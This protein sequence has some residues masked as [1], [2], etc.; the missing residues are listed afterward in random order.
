MTQLDRVRELLAWHA[1][2]AL[3]GQD[4][5]FMH[6]WLEANLA[7]HPEIAA[8]MAWLRNTAEQ[9]QA[10]VQAQ[11]NLAQ[12]SESL[13]LST[14]MQRIALEK[15]GNAENLAGSNAPNQNPPTSNSRVRPQAGSQVA[16]GDR[17]AV[18]LKDVLGAR[19]PA[20][21]LGVAAVVIAQASIIGALLV[22]APASQEPLGGTVDA[23][24]M[25]ADKVFLTVA[26]SPLASE[27][28]LRTVLASANAQ[29]V[30]GPSALGLYTV[31]VPRDKADILAAQLLAAVGVVD[32][33][34]R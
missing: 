23:I 12:Q 29:I 8:E 20:L 13:G 14:L 17:I 27:L 7:N 28:A 30:A 22:K 26:F 3:T 33:V 2:G 15:A 10:Q 32:S 4:L 18:W 21:A 19:S 16:W 9:L 25:S 31:A 34:Q 11:A 1:R 24:T 6:Q 5:A